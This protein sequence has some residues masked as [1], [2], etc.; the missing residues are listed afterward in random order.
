MKSQGFPSGVALFRELA[1]VW[2][3]NQMIVVMGLGDI[4]QEKVRRHSPL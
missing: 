4:L 2:K 3:V 1:S